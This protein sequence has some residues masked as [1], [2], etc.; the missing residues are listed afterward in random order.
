MTLLAILLPCLGA[1]NALYFKH[2]LQLSGTNFLPFAL[3]LLQLLFTTILGTLFSSDIASSEGQ[4]CRLETQWKRFWTGHDEQAI[5]HIQD[6]FKCCGF[7]TVKDRAWPFPHGN[8]NDTQPSCAVQ[9]NR[10]V[11]C[12][13]PWEKA[14]QRNNSIGLFIVVVVAL[15]QVGGM[16]FLWWSKARD[17]PAWARGFGGSATSQGYEQGQAT[18]SL[19]QGVEDDEEGRVEEDVSE[20]GGGD[21]TTP[22]TRGYGTRGLGPQA[23]RNTEN[24]WDDNGRPW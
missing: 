10:D 3:Q 20:S 1:L 13:G 22:G 5:R 15:L 12:I 4:Q 11:P 7:R 17:G 16:L 19:L 14:L 2:Q 8:P 21:G 6:V 18:Q 24:T 23:S 9:F